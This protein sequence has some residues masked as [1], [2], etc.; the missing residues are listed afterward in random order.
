MSQQH[1]EPCNCND[2]EHQKHPSHEND[3]HVGDECVHPNGSKHT[4]HKK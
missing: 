4:I 2:E 3:E 1:E